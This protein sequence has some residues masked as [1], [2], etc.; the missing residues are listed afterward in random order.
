MEAVN[1]PSPGLFAF[2]L[3][4]LATAD[5]WDSSANVC[6]NRLSQHLTLQ[7]ARQLPCAIGEVIGLL[8]GAK[9]NLQ[10]ASDLVASFNLYEAA[11]HL[12]DAALGH[13]NDWDHRLLLNAASI[14]GHPS[15]HE[16][17]RTRVAE[18]VKDIPAAL[19]RL[20]PS[21][22]TPNERLIRLQRRCWPG[23]QTDDD[24][25][26]L[27]PTVVFD[28]SVDRRAMLWLS[29]ALHRYGYAIR[30][31]GEERHLPEWFGNRTAVVC[32]AESAHRFLMESRLEESQ[33][34]T[35]REGIL[36]ENTINQVLSEIWQSRPAN[37][38]SDTTTPKLSDG[39]PPRESR[40]SESLTNVEFWDALYEDSLHHAMLKPT[41]MY[42]LTHTSWKD[43]IAPAAYDLSEGESW[44]PVEKHLLGA[45][46]KSTAE[47]VP[48]VFEPMPPRRA[49]AI[50]DEMVTNMDSR[51]RYRKLKSA[52][53]T[54]VG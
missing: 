14:S 12:V 39:T 41:G 23:L 37:W 34:I 53:R 25:Y 32:T 24:D 11:S 46:H 28:S 16:S 36:D 6:M 2:V 43:K 30:R 22:P 10:L 17:V 48:S 18:A 31:I 27:P 49:G 51:R 52:Y 47:Y 8:R 45:S 4:V 44:Y 26:D 9:T 54:H 38:K 5:P 3:R 40:R 13:T 35:T 19:V 50:D 7:H 33:I 21:A 20:D 1:A 42:L 29:G 15:V